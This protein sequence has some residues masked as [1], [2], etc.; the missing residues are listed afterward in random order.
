MCPLTFYPLKYSFPVSLSRIAIPDSISYNEIIMN[1]NKKTQIMANKSKVHFFW[2]NECSPVGMNIGV[3]ILSSEL[4]SVGHSVMVSHVSSSLGYPFEARHI[5]KDIRNFCADVFA[6]SFPTSQF[7]LVP[8]L[9]RIIKN[10]RPKSMVV[11][12]GVHAI[13]SPETVINIPGV[14]AVCVGEGDGILRQFLEQIDSGKSWERMNGFWTRNNGITYRPPPA[15]LPDITDQAPLYFSGINYKT[16]VRLKGG[17]AEIL[18]GRGCRFKCSFCQNHIFLKSHCKSKTSSYVRTRGVENLMN[19]MKTFKKEVGSDLKG[20]AFGDDSIAYEKNWTRNFLNTYK[21]EIDMPFIASLTVVQATQPFA[22]ALYEAGCNVIRIGLETGNEQLRTGLLGKPVTDA[23]LFRAS[24]QLHNAG[25]NIQG[26]GMIALP[27][28]T[29][30]DI[31]K[32]LSLAVELRLDALRLSTFVPLP[33][34]DLYI[35][36]LEKNLFKCLN[37]EHHNFVSESALKWSASMALFHEKIR[38]AFPIIMNSFLP[39]PLRNLYKS[40]ASKILQS[41]RA[42]WIK[43]KEELPHISEQ[44]HTRAAE[45][46]LPHYFSPVADRLDYTF[47]YLPDR[48]RKMINVDDAHA[49]IHTNHNGK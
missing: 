23:A 39:D 7:H 13:V 40:V 32:M 24:Q 16:L 15:P 33:K 26:F 28:E 12:G 49:S 27:G 14:D 45:S 41:S 10:N 8:D 21:Q 2:L 48:K 31:L 1:A 5:S 4:S 43:L 29:D 6:I 46:A 42:R 35:H 18:L 47:L 38:F 19:E 9:V 37:A 17:F 20:F 30:E 11:C 22:H 36:C 3:S 25:I 44:L 34:T